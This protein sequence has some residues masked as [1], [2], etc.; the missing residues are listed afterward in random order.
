MTMDY[1]CSAKR[2]EV[3]E[4]QALDGRPKGARGRARPKK[5]WKRTVL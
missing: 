5:T 4:K 3:I 2:E 1:P